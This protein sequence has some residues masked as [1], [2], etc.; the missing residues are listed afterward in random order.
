MASLDGTQELAM[1]GGRLAVLLIEAI[2][3]DVGEALMA[4]LTESRQVA[5]HC[6]CAR[7]DS[8]RGRAALERL[9]IDTDDSNLTGGGAIDLDAERL[10]LVF[11][12]HPKDISLPASNS[13]VTLRGPL[14]EPRVE[15]VSR[16]LVARGGLSVLGA[17]VAPPLAILP[18]IEPG[19][20]ESV[21]PGC[22]RV[23]EDFPAAP[24]GES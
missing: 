14:E 12:A 18:W 17:Q 9:F 10:E 19:T 20:G 4:A 22:R 7:L 21:G 3:L 1:A 8:D 11:E 13:P 23:L 6:A 15:V 2:G 5:M 16:E 24:A